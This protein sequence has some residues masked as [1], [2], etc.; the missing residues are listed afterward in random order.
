MQTRTLFRRS[1]T[2]DFLFWQR[3]KKSRSYLDGLQNFRAIYLTE[4]PC[5]HSI[6][7][8]TTFG[9]LRLSHHELH[10]L[11]LQLGDL[12]K[13][14]LKLFHPRLCI[15]LSQ[16]IFGCEILEVSD[17]LFGL[18]LEQKVGQGPAFR[19]GVS[20]CLRLPESTVIADQL[21]QRICGADGKI[22]LEDH[23]VVLVDLAN[24][25]PAR[26]MGRVWGLKEDRQSFADPKRIICQPNL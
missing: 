20:R 10:E 8:A 7:T 26:T 19:V 14:L 22:S 18:G 9:G 1:E 6:S 4:K 3:C 17:V 24:A 13:V 21:S 25:P 15:A 16:R 2:E 11:P 12:A 23:Q 5:H